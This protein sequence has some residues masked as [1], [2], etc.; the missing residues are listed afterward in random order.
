MD[1]SQTTHRVFHKLVKLIKTNV[2]VYNANQEIVVHIL[3]VHA[4]P[5]M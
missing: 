3:E 1:L 2:T 5:F 4:I